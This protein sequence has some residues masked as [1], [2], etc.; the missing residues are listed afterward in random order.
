MTSTVRDLVINR[1]HI[2]KRATHNAT[3]LTS[4]VLHEMIILNPVSRE[5]L[6]SLIQEVSFKS[7]N[8]DDFTN[9]LT[10]RCNERN[11]KLPHIPTS[12][13]LKDLYIRFQKV[14]RRSGI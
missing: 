10:I 2:E 4:F 8:A 5:E 3:A 14:L 11:L 6:Y 7:K 1:E 13:E 9:E 12:T